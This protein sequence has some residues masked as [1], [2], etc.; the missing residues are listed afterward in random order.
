[1]IVVELGPGSVCGCPPRTWQALFHR[2]LESEKNIS[3]IQGNCSVYGLLLI[4]S[5]PSLTLRYRLLTYIRPLTSAPTL[6]DAGP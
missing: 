6:V 5:L 4:A 1:M 3:S 2:L